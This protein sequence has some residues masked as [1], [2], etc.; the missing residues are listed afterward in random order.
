[1]DNRK[2]VGADRSVPPKNSEQPK[3]HFTVEST[4]PITVAS[5]IRSQSTDIPWSQVRK[6]LEQGHVFVDGQVIRE[7]AFRVSSGN[8]VEL[9]NRGVGTESR[10]ALHALFDKIKIVYIDEHIIVVDKPSGMVTQNLPRTDEEFEAAEHAEEPTL[11]ELIVP[12]VKRIVGKH[13]EWKSGAPRIVN[14][15]DKDTSGLLVFAR[16]RKAFDSLKKQFFEHTIDR[17]Y[18]A[19]VAGQ[20]EKNTTYQS[21]LVENR[22]DGFR[23]SVDTP[24]PNAKRS[25][26]H[27][28]PIEYFRGATLIRCRL[29]TGRTHQIRIHLSE[30][31]HPLL[32]D[33]IY[34][35]RGVNRNLPRPPRLA[36]HAR[37]LGFIHPGGK[38][39]EFESELPDDL[40]KW[41]KK[42]PPV[43][44]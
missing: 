28:K 14:R 32:G 8:V 17:E 42:L 26:T 19:V 44:R 38:R 37:L 35:E 23:G 39:V 9:R 6:W 3:L 12:L 27:V 40:K 15:T 21:Y 43:L 20:I 33:P 1:M 5:A 4:T 16:T 31:G 29:E 11:E 30:A 34:G 2:K 7:E 36:L 41:M 25:V 18:L 24:Q 13:P 10:S 22:G